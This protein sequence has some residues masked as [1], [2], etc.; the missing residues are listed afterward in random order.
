VARDPHFDSNVARENS[1]YD[2]TPSWFRSSWSKILRA[3]VLGAGAVVASLGEGALGASLRA[4][5]VV[6][7]LCIGAL[8]AV[9]GVANPAVACGSSG[10]T[11]RVPAVAAGRVEFGAV[12]DAGL[13]ALD[14]VPEV[15]AHAVPATLMIA[16]ATAV[17]RCLEESFIGT[18]SNVGPARARLEQNACC[19]EPAAA[20]RLILRGPPIASGRRHRVGV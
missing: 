13:A 14:V 16:A 8:V 3:W 4:G 11:V 1:W 19:K 6:G 9:P 12:S 15:V 18:P 5:A 17:T 2:S 20:K 10:C 7:S